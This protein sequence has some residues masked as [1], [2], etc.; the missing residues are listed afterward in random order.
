MFITGRLGDIHGHKLTL[1]LGWLWF[2]LWSLISGFCKPTQLVWFGTC[3]ALQGIGPA[4]VIPNAIALIGRTFPMGFKRNMAF[5]CFGAAGPTGAA[6][7]AVMAALISESE[8]LGWHWCFFLL[9]I[10]CLFVAAASW[11]IIPSPEQD[12]DSPEKGD[13]EKPTFDW[14]GTLTGVSGLILLNFAL[15]QAPIVGW[16]EPYIAP[17]LVLGILFLIA[18]IYV[19]L[20]P[21]TTQPIIPL[22]GLQRNAAFTLACVF[23]GW[24]SHGIWVYYL[25]I[26]LQHL[27]GHSALLTSAE[28]SPVAITGILFAFLT[29]HLLRKT[30]VGWIMFTAMFFF[31]FGSLLIATTPLDQTYWANTFVAV[32]LMPGAMNLSFPAATILLSEAL[33]KEKQGIA[34]SL[35]ATVVNYSI[36][37]GL[38]FAGSIH[39]HT[40]IEAANRLG[41]HG[42]APPLSDVSDERLVAARLAGLRSAYWFAV[43]LGALGMVVAGLFVLVQR[44]DGKR[45]AGRE[46]Q[47]RYGRG[48]RSNDAEK[49]EDVQVNSWSTHEHSPFGTPPLRKNSSRG[50]GEVINTFYLGD[51][52]IR[53]KETVAK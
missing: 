13:K 21:T 7:G 6:L 49:A 51:K 44:V 43:A 16:S 15:N 23:T 24:S 27:R 47:K 17:L 14:T 37:C 8:K 26:L 41:M 25:Y 9:A 50:G 42:P 12:A 33:P 3:R 18:F 32:V 19:E 31:M 30:S 29:V 48:R 40:L 2:A 53:V 4:L 10:T 34:A 5:A 11:V 28:T 45:R 35:V 46:G 20:H 39:K 38:G 1:L 52:V 22:R 36:S